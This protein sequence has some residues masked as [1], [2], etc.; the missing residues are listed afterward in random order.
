[1][2][3]NDNKQFE[4]F[5]KNNQKATNEA[6]K[7]YFSSRI[8]GNFLIEIMNKVMQTVFIPNYY[9]ISFD[10]NTSVTGISDNEFEFE[11]C[12]MI[13]GCHRANTI[14]MSDSERGSLQLDS[15]YRN[16]LIDQVVNH[17]KIRKYA[18]VYFRK[19]Q[20]VPGDEFIFFPVLYKLF[21]IC[22]YATS[23][24]NERMLKYDLY[25]NIFSKS[26]ASMTMIENNFMDC[27]Y[28]LVRGIIEI[29]FK[30]L[31][32]NS[33]KIKEEYDKFIMW[34]IEKTATIENSNDFLDKFKDRI[35][36]KDTNKINYSHYGW[37]DSIDDY[38]KIVKNNPYSIN[39]VF[40]YIYNMID[41]DTKKTFGLVRD[42]YNRCHEFLHGNIGNQGIPLLHY[43]ELTIA[44][45]YV[46]TMSY[47][48]LCKEYNISDKIDDIDLISL[49][50]DDFTLLIDQYNKRSTENF[51]KYYNVKF[52]DV[53]L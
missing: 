24:I 21:A 25:E 44:L 22:T 15:K 28:S 19:R 10:I 38:H 13:V 23:L 18:S 12:R 46:V 3:S 26:L 1:M 50:Y 2:I 45:Y 8:K 29:F 35:Y 53:I 49:V 31:L 32:I 30:S 17:I 52:R 16:K 37:V 41:E 42:V 40:D 43:F 9:N 11:I 33:K 48:Y 27:A 47:I 4:L 14:F 34:G 5:A 51:E 7:Q 20:L 39:G 36:K 6:L